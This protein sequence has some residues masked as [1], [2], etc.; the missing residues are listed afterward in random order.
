[1][2]RHENEEKLTKKMKFDKKSR[3]TRFCTFFKKN[4]MKKI[5]YLILKKFDD[6]IKKR[7]NDREKNFVKND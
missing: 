1:M 6:Y 3:A 4:L 5:F 2:C 7:K